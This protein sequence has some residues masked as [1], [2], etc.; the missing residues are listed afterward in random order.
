MELISAEIN[1]H[2]IVSIDEL[3]TRLDTSRS[4]IC[5]DLYDLEIEH[6]LTR[7]RG[8]AVA[9]K[10]MTS[11]EPPF[12]V[13]KDFFLDEKQRIAEA[14]AKLVQ[15]NET[16]LLDGGT[17]V[18]ELAK[19]L[20]KK[21]SLYIATNDLNSAMI[22]SHNT[23]IELTVF[24]GAL[25]KHHYSLHGYF[26]DNMIKQIHADKLFL[27]VD[28][29]DF[30]IGYMNFSVEEIQTKKLMIQASSEVIV[31]CDHS[32]FEKIAFV[33]ICH[34]NEVDLVITGKEID[35]KTLKKI[36]AMNIKVLVV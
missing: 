30:N 25:R 21:N 36:E 20:R 9:I 27:G 7:T 2:G 26:T 35:E 1:Q 31:L 33:N 18:F 19:A 5:R 12:D 8:G 34:F 15:E 4:T 32:K 28:A 16:L 13:R 23:N 29:V 24:G 10:N 14:A 3:T 6:V 11:Y 17:T 22:L